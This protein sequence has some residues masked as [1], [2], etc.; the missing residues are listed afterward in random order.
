MNAHASATPRVKSNRRR[1]FSA[2]FCAVIKVSSGSRP[3]WKAATFV[4][5]AIYSAT[6]RVVPVRLS[7]WLAV[8]LIDDENLNSSRS[9]SAIDPFIVGRPMAGFALG[10]FSRIEFGTTVRR[11]RTDDLKIGIRDAA[12]RAG[13]SLRVLSYIE[14][15]RLVSIDATLAACRFIKVHP[16]AFARRTQAVVIPIETRSAA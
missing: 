6:H 16:F 13:L 15:G 1:S 4:G 3:S 7:A 14:N 8:S 11:Y 10:R 2:R 5:G 9:E 12:I